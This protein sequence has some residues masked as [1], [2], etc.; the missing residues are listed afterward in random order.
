M[1]QGQELTKEV[2][3]AIRDLRTQGNS[4]R[5][6]A[7]MLSISNGSVLKHSP[8]STSHENFTKTK[9]V[10]DENLEKIIDLSG[11]RLV[12]VLESK[13]KIGPVALNTVMGTAWDKRYGKEHTGVESPAHVLIALF[14]KS[15]A[16]E[17]IA[18]NLMKMI[19]QVKVIEGP[20][21]EGKSDT[22]PVVEA[23]TDA[24]VIPS[25]STPDGDTVL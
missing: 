9:K 18:H 25:P 17:K 4:V 10:R 7:L 21:V 14:G 1:I 20:A 6:T 22:P 3:K 12:D 5:K 11:E 19:P 16:G 23:V 2:I 13:D 24:E 8:G 15:G